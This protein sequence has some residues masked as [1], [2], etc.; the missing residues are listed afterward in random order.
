LGSYE[1]ADNIKSDPLFVDVSAADY[2]L[3]ATSPAR[4]AGLD[5]GLTQDYFGN[6]VPYPVGGSPDIGAVEWQPQAAEMQCDDG[7]DNDHDARTDCEDSDCDGQTC[8]ANGR[9]CKNNA[10]VCSNG[11]V[12]ADCGTADGSGKMAETAETSPEMAMG[13]EIRKQ[14][15][16]E[17]VTEGIAEISAMHL[18]MASPSLAVALQRSVFEPVAWVGNQWTL[19][20]RFLRRWCTRGWVTS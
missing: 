18:R 6:P 10:C 19:L 5:V 8:G 16:T 2:R 1:S 20:A 4:D 7:L 3:Q 17:G 14:E 15:A 9:K 13:R 12:A 11:S